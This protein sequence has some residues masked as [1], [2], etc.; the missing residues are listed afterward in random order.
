MRAWTTLAAAA[1]ALLFASALGAAIAF[2]ALTGRVVDQAAILPAAARAGL[3]QL[4]AAHEQSTSNQVVVVTLES[5]QGH[6]I[7]DYGYQLGR[8]WGIGQEG[9]DNGVL[10]IIAPAERK[11]RIEV[12]YGLEGTLT[13][14]LASNIIQRVVLP[15]FRQGDM[16]AGTVEGARAILQV[17]E[18]TYQPLPGR[19]GGAEG[20]YDNFMGWFI[21]LVIAGEA[22]A[23]LVPARPVSAALLGGGALLIGWLALGSLLAGAVMAVL[24]SVF[25]LM[26]GGGGNGGLPGGGG[27]AISGGRRRS[28]IGRSGGF[29]GGG[30]SFGGGGASGGW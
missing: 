2:P 7:E 18:G 24:I 10:L 17:I 12:G 16:A 22:L 29:R 23:R 21:F 28:G 5:L 25:H 11:V 19:R 8:Y 13:D 27:G 26:I 4:L 14:A 3:E 6:A 1:A 15:R 20:R 30:G 9:R